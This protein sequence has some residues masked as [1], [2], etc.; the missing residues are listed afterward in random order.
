MDV[1]G[2]AGFGWRWMVLFMGIVYD[3]VESSI[4]VSILQVIILP[5][6]LL[7]L[8]SQYHH[9]KSS[10]RSN[11]QYQLGLSINNPLQSKRQPHRNLPP[12]LPKPPR[13][14]P[15][16]LQLQCIRQNLICNAHPDP[17]PGTARPRASRPRALLRL[18]ADHAAEELPAHQGERDA[19]DLGVFDGRRGGESVVEELLC[20]DG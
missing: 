11:D 2:L 20:L 5:I 4:R 14:L 17:I 16:P 8:V 15:L 19:R 1:L 6:H 18:L 7:E 3:T 10:Q 9:S 12:L 13:L